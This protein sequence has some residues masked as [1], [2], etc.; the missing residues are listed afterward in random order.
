MFGMFAQSEDKVY[1]NRFWQVCERIEATLTVDEIDQC[2]KVFDSDAKGY[3]TFGD[4]SRV[5]SLVQGYEIDKICNNGEPA[6]TRQMG[7]RC[8]GFKE[9]YAQQYDE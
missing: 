7:K 4:F 1:K 8:Q 5:S 2:F 6:I 9:F 3:F